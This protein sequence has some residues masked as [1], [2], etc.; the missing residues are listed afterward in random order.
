MLLDNYNSVSNSEL[1]LMLPNKSINSICKKARKM[2]IKKA[3]EMEFLN[4]SEAR[5]GTLASNW[6]GGIRKTSGGY[7][8]LLVPDHPRADKCGYVME[9]II[10]WERETGMILP[11]G[12]CIHHLNGDKTDNRIEN[13]CVMQHRAHTVFHHTGKKRSEETKRKIREARRRTNVKSYNLDGT[14][15]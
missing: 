8:Q 12:L 7:R 3:R 1:K 10:V 4:R 6:K 11:P 9:H 2:G 15:R 14:N 13:L 5:K